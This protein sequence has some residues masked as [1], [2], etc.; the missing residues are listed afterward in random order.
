MNRR[1]F[2]TGA[3][4]LVAAPAVVPFASLMPV[5]GIVMAIQPYGMSPGTRAML[6]IQEWLDE[7]RRVVAKTM[8]V[9]AER[10]TFELSPQ[11]MASLVGSP[12]SPY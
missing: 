9:P 1:S 3:L 2:L 6:D 10:F 12:A 11:A 5:R 8:G 4:G 7:C